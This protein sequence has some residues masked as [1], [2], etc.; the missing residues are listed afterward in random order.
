MHQQTVHHSRPS[1]FA[2]ITTHPL[3]HDTT[4]FYN[5]IQFI[6]D[7][8]KKKKESLIQPMNILGYASERK[9]PTLYCFDIRWTVRALER[10]RAVLGHLHD[11]LLAKN[12]AAQHQHWWIIFS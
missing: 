12:M 4:S 11:R 1:A 7:T 10:F 6:T 8:E 5:T 2:T 3:L 9:L